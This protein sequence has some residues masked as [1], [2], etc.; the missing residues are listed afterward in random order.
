MP[1]TVIIADDEEHI[2]DL[3]S[4]A[5]EYLSYEV[6][7]KANNGQEA[8]DLYKENNPYLLLLDIN[9][10]VK[11]GIEV[12]EEILEYN[13]NAF[14]IFLSINVLSKSNAKLLEMINNSNTVFFIRKDNPL[15]K[16]VSLIRNSIKMYEENKS[17]IKFDFKEIML[18]AQEDEKYSV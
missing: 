9:M 8:V 4:S 10:P 17:K 6:I 7:G 1:K 3:F 18:E 2:R 15:P 11:K 14:I 13:H 5:M 12:A 16:I